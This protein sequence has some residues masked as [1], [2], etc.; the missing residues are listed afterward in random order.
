MQYRERLYQLIAAIDNYQDNYTSR[1]A[2]NTVIE[3]ALDLVVDVLTN[4]RRIADALEA[5]NELQREILAKMDK[6]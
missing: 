5:G 3:L 1:A 6:R 2:V 4:V